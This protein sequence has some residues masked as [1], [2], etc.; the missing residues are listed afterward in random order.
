[1]IYMYQDITDYNIV[2][3]TSKISKLKLKFQQRK[4]HVGICGRK[5]Q[6]I[7]FSKYDSFKHYSYLN[8]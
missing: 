8:K 7:S 1:M 4:L 6:D 5:G 3:V 2:I